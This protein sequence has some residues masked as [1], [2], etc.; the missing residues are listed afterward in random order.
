MFSQW[1]TAEDGARRIKWQLVGLIY[2][3]ASLAEANPNEKS[4]LRKE[5]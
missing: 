1:E 4:A 3:V 5:V 2:E